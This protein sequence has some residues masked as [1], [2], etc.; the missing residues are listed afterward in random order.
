MSLGRRGR[1]ENGISE[2]HIRSRTQYAV[3][4]NRSQGGVVL[5][6]STQVLLSVNMHFLK[7]TT[8]VLKPSISAGIYSSSEISILFL[9]YTYCLLS[10]R[11]C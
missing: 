11:S 8:Q 7:E 6:H 3:T 9:C 10:S 1:E 4:V 5:S 2:M